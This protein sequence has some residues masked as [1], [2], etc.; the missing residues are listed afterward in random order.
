MAPFP[1]QVTRPIQYGTKLKAH[2]VYMSQFQLIPY[3]RIQDHFRDQVN[4]ALSAGT[5]YNF[6]AQAHE[7]LETFD[8]LAAD[9]LAGSPLMHADETG[10][11]VNGKTIWLHSASNNRWT[12]FRVHAKRGTA[13]IDDIGIVP[14]FNGILCHDH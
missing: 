11:N 9:T 10:V 7:M 4:L 3:E 1:A 13:A 12:H 2:A 5:L 6:N 14:R 8:A